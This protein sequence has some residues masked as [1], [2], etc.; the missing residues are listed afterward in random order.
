[1]ELERGSVLAGKYRIDGVLGKG[2]MA[3]VYRATNLDLDHPVAVK[4]QSTATLDGYAVERF[5]REARA[6]ARLRTDHVVRVFDVGRLEDQTPYI[7]M[8]ELLGR[9]LDRRLEEGPLSVTETA[10]VV[11]QVCAALAE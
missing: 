5:L 8:E 11:I 7:V 6:T 9:P 3:V 10:D 1:M 4:L 2:G